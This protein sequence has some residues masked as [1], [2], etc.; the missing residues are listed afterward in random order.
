MVCKRGDFE[1]NITHERLYISVSTFFVRNGGGVRVPLALPS[2]RPWTRS[3]ND[4][5]TYMLQVENIFKLN[6]QFF[7]LPMKQKL[8]YRR[9]EGMDHHGYCPVESERYVLQAFFQ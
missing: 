2:L 3:V 7:D 1:R 5:L 6:E 8:S 9:G 4:L